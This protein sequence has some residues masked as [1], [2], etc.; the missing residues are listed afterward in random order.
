M[1]D[2][3]PEALTEG[4]L[5]QERGDNGTA[6]IKAATGARDPEA[7]GEGGGKKGTCLGRARTP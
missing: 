6:G 2:L 4:P 5:H 3:S 1:I 7:V